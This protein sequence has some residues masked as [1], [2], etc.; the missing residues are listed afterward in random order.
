[1]GKTRF[2]SLSSNLISK[3]LSLLVSPPFEEYSVVF[4]VVSSI[5]INMCSLSGIGFY[6][7][8]WHGGI[9]IGSKH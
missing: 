4:F 1:M 3:T 2:D 9:G 8:R 7:L 5:A 6:T